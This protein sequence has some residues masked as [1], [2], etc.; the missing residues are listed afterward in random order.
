MSEVGEQTV[1]LVPNLRR[2]DEDIQGAVDAWIR[3]PAVAEARYG[4]ISLWDT[5]AVTNMGGL[6]S[7]DRC[8]R[9]NIR[10][11][12]EDLSAWI[13]TNVTDLSYMFYDATS[14]NCDISAWDTSSVTSMSRT[15]CG[16][17]SFNCGGCDL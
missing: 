3:D 9:D 15:F 8:G 1:E 13:T 2:T 10:N 6:F 14:F 11:F 17:T 12:N 16:A 7:S 4:Q 5:S